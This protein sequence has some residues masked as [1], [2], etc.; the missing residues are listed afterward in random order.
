MH[1]EPT[2]ISSWKDLVDAFLKQYKYNMDMAPDRMQLQN[3]AKQISETFKEYAQRWRELAAQVEP[4][5]YEKEMITMFIETLQ[6]PFYKH[7]LGS[8]SSNFS[9]IVTI[10]ERIEHGLKSGK[11]AQGSSTAT[12]AK[13][14]GFDPSKK[15]EG[16]VQAISTGPY[17]GGYRLQYL[18]NYRPS[19][20]YVANAMP[21]YSQ[22]TPR[23]PT[24]YRPPF[25]PNNAF[26]PKIQLEVRV[27]I[28][29]KI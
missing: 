26:Q 15:K 16:E 25:T 5:L 17:W 27:L 24:A 9:D 14:P 22:N 13:K 2:R 20:A 4:P 28:K 19:S 10:G 18:P 29:H 23:P 3:M 12:S 8:V 11:I 1:L 21:G 6:D 7:V